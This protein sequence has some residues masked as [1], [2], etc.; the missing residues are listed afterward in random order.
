MENILFNKTLSKI[1][2]DFGPDI[3]EDGKRFI[4]IFCD[5]SPELENE[6]DI[7]RFISS[8]NILDELV[9]AKYETDEQRRKTCA[10]AIDFIVS[11]KHIS[12]KFAFEFIKTL[13]EVLYGKEFVLILS[14]NNNENIPE[15]LKKAFYILF[16]CMDEYL[17]NHGI[18]T[19]EIDNKVWFETKD[20]SIFSKET[21]EK[22]GLSELVVINLAMDDIDKYLREENFKEAF[23]YCKKI[24]DFIASFNKKEL[25]INLYLIFIRLVKMVLQVNLILSEEKTDLLYYV[26]RGSIKLFNIEKDRSVIAECNLLCFKLLNLH[27]NEQNSVMKKRHLKIATEMYCKLESEKTV[28]TYLNDK[29][30]ICSSIDRKHWFFR[31]ELEFLETAYE[32]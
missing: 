12:E 9:K 32:I 11:Q 10:E 27:K 1:V 25:L 19:N 5:Y 2:S 22:L 28:Y 15:N 21:I 31:K 29:K 6:A 30:K 24:I 7:L 18:A 13:S 16:N 8:N 3:F 14:F 17:Q 23:I 4:S 20:I 26:L